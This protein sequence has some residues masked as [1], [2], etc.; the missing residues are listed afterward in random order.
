FVKFLSR[1]IVKFR[2]SFQSP[3]SF[4]TF[5]LIGSLNL[6][7]KELADRSI[8]EESKSYRSRFFLSRAVFKLFF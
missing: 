2:R 8:S 5:T 7:F 3:S 4:P 1:G 6:I